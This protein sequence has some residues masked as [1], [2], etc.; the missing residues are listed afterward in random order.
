M[1]QLLDI[2]D[3][4][5]RCLTLAWLALHQVLRVPS[6]SRDCNQ[7]SPRRHFQALRLSPSD[8]KY[9]CFLFIELF[10]YRICVLKPESDLQ[11]RYE[12]FKWIHQHNP[13]ERRT[14]FEMCFEAMQTGD[15]FTPEMQTE[16]SPSVSYLSYF[17]SSFRLNSCRT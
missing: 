11:T 14:G 16:L 12:L 17:P 4:P 9:P 8:L 2:V 7:R 5:A 6:E 1:S 10:L 13:Y 15:C 3:A